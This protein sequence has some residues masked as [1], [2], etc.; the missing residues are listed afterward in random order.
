MNK[1]YSLINS[2]DA[3]EYEVKIV[4]RGLSA[5]TS[6]FSPF[7]AYDFGYMGKTIIAGNPKS[8]VTR[9]ITKLGCRGRVP[10]SYSVEDMFC[11]MLLHEIGHYEAEGGNLAFT[12]LT[13]KDMR[14]R[15]KDL[16][17][18]MKGMTRIQKNRYYAGLP[19]EKEADEYALLKM[20]EI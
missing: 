18:A 12:Q 8:I 3:N 14:K 2:I 4:P 5:I 7:I 19:G 16:A 13:Y 10:D 9:I 1:F 11:F 6:L 17:K 15:Q 20:Q